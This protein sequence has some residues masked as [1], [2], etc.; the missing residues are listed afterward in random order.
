MNMNRQ[1]KIQFIKAYHQR[2]YD[3]LKEKI[4][5]IIGDEWIPSKEDIDLYNLIVKDYCK[6]YNISLMR[7]LSLSMW[8][9]C[10]PTF[11]GVILMQKNPPKVGEK[12][13]LNILKKFFIFVFIDYS[14][15]YWILQVNNGFIHKSKFM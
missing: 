12:R 13:I 6:D 11:G 4:P 10:S 15:D 8:G 14:E 3:E 7:I 1:Q 9:S 5:T 2:L